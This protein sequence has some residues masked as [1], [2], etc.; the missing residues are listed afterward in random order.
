MVS[1]SGQVP[2][3]LVGVHTVSRKVEKLEA[4]AQE[5]DSP[6]KRKSEILVTLDSL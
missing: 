3:E 2:S 4:F 1:D 6:G 5:C